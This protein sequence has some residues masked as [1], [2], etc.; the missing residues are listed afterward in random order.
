MAHEIFRRD[1]LALAA[2]E[3]HC[4]RHGLPMTEDGR[5]EWVKEWRTLDNEQR[6]GAVKAE[7]DRALEWPQAHDESTLE[8]QEPDMDWDKSTTAG[9]IEIRWRWGSLEGFPGRS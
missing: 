8:L 1:R 7:R 6:Q 9:G 2:Y 3:D 5:S 4:T